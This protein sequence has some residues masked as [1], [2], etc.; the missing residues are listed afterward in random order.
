MGLHVNA[1]HI[2]AC[3]LRHTPRDPEVTTEQSAGPNSVQTA[4]AAGPASA[5]K[6]ACVGQRIATHLCAPGALYIL[7]AGRLY[8]LPRDW[9]VRADSAAAS[10]HG[11]MHVRGVY[12]GTTTPTLK[13][14]G[15][16]QPRALGWLSNC[17]QRA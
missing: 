8:H 1:L 3:V 17:V 12:A 13:L 7:D 14:P 9:K 5:A 4:E 10:R 11:R 2:D 6:G 15:V 16:L